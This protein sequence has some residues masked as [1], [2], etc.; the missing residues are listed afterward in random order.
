MSSFYKIGCDEEKLPCGFDPTDDRDLTF[1]CGRAYDFIAR[2]ARVAGK[3]TPNSTIGYRRFDVSEDQAIVGHFFK[4]VRD[5]EF[6]LLVLDLFSDR[7]DNRQKFSSIPNPFPVLLY[8]LFR[9]ITCLF[10]H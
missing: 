9:C 6:I 2:A 7:V 3:P 5:R 8:Q 1:V 4:K 10:V